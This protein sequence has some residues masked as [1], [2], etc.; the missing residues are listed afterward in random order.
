M[1]IPD[2][3]KNKEIKRFIKYCL[4]GG[5][6][7]L[8]CLGVIFLC[9]SVLGV[10]IYLSNVLGYSCGVVNSFIWNKQWVFN[11]EGRLHREAVKFL[12]GCGLCYLI[13]LGI[14]YLLMRTSLKDTEILIAGFTLSG[15]G[16]S[17]LIGN[18]VYTVCNFIYNR[19]IT[20]TSRNG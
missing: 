2:I 13:Q 5:L 12:I 10:N 19:R 16:I 8:I 7:T 3:I 9:K 6:N 1:S 15:Y 17:T 14:I 11:S 4:V 20:F 18:I